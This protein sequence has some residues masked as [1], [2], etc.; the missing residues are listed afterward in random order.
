MSNGGSTGIKPVTDNGSAGLFVFPNPV[1][2]SKFD[3]NMSATLQVSDAVITLTDVLG[4]GVKLSS[5]EKHEGGYTVYLTN[6]IQSGLYNLQ[7]KSG[8]QQLSVKLIVIK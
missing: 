2:G 8:T 6:N 5:I 1:T 4:R 7:Y 3:I